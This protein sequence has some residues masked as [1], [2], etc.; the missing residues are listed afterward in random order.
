MTRIKFPQKTENRAKELLQLVHSDVCGPMQIQSPSGKRYVSTFID[1]FSKFAT[2]Y[3]LK[4]KSETL[5]CFK[6]YVEIC[7]TMFGRKPKFITK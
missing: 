3:L 1:D 2:I 5:S 6:D 7:K 4:E